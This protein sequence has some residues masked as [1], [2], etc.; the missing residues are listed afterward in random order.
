MLW[1]H[2]HPD[3]TVDD[4]RYRQ[5]ALLY[6]FILI[7]A[8]YFG[9]IGTLNLVLF[10]DEAIAL[11][12]FAGFACTLG[13][14]AYTRRTAQFRRASWA[15]VLTLIGVLAGF[16]W[17]ARGASYSLLWITVL[18]PIAFFLLGVRAGSWVTGLFF[19]FVMVF[20]AVVEPNW[21]QVH[22][23]QG[24]LLNFAEVMTAHWFLFRHYEISRTEA[25]QQL[26]ESAAI[27]RLTGLW[28]RMRLDEA[29][30]DTLAL[31]RRTGRGTA[32][33]LADVDHF[34][35]I[36]D[37]HGHLMGDD[38]LREI[39]RILQRG[40]RHTDRVGRWGGEEFL[41]LCPDTDAEGARIL[42]EK[43]R[44]AV[45]AGDYPAGVAVTVSVGVAAARGDLDADQ[46]LQIA[47][48][49]LYRAKAGGRDCV[50]V[51][52]SDGATVKP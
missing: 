21:H 24:A 9:V 13:I 45:A 8:L 30:A 15:A 20:L 34:K 29:L 44:A 42:A 1:R 32:V 5:V 33:L 52:Q 47:D 14:Y 7:M 51:E 36:N 39:A 25:Y 16:T 50:M 6:A 19:T 2:H 18:P 48:R 10:G 38:V 17:L 28:N 46:F 11:F 27:D 26:K 4:P 41:V 43:V 37:V 22:L 3:I 35:Q 12:D 31:A 40:I 49:Q 23:S